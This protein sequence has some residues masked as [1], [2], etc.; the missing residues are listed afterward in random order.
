[1]IVRILPLT[2]PPPLFSRDNSRA[3]GSGADAIHSYVGKDGKRETTTTLIND[4]YKKT[5][6]VTVINA[7]SEQARGGGADRMRRKWKVKS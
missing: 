1:M 2:P 7:D 4:V 5:P 6:L 3:S